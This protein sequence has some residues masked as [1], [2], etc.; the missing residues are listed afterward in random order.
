MLF[1]ISGI[2]NFDNHQIL[3]FEIDTVIK[4]SFFDGE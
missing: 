3:E 2:I 1:T 4:E